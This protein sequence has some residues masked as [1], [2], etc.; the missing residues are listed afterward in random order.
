MTILPARHILIFISLVSL[1]IGLLQLAAFRAHFSL[2]S[3]GLDIWSFAYWILLAMWVDAD[4]RGRHP[5]YRPY[6]FGWL[7]FV[8]TPFYLIYYLIRTRGA[9]GVLWLL[10]FLA[11]V[12]LGGLLQWAALL[13]A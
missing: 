2:D 8:A 7:V 4:S 6:E 5:V 13:L 11:L 1:G 12:A 10:Y 3:G 9:P